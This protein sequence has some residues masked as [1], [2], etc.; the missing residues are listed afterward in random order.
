DLLS[1]A[2]L[3][4]YSNL[5]EKLSSL[6]CNYL[7]KWFELVKEVDYLIGKGVV[8]SRLKY[9]FDENLIHRNF[10]LVPNMMLTYGDT[11]LDIIDNYDDI[12]SEVMTERVNCCELIAAF[13]QTVFQAAFE[14][15]NL[16]VEH[17]FH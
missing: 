3:A 5:L 11:L 12:D 7:Q 14:K 2:L 16:L 1:K 9:H 15:K 13:L 6:K 8:V 10:T 17:K 4:C